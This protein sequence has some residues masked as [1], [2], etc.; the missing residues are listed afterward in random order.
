[1]TLGKSGGAAGR[2][3]ESSGMAV[4]TSR[5]GAPVVMVKCDEVLQLRRA[6]G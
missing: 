6:R 1:V 5:E 4:F 2:Q 3:E